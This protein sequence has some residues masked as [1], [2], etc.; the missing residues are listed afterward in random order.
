MSDPPANWLLV[1]RSLLCSTSAQHHIRKHANKWICTMDQPCICFLCAPPRIPS[2][3]YLVYVFFFTFHELL[4]FIG[5]DTNG[6]QYG[7]ANLALWNWW[8]QT[9]SIW[10]ERFFLLLLLLLLLPSPVNFYWWPPFVVPFHFCRL[11]L[12]QTLSI[13]PHWVDLMFLCS[14]SVVGHVG[15][16]ER[17]TTRKTTVV[18]H[19]YPCRT[20]PLF[21]TAAA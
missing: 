8:L 1:I 16:L 6:V 20:F 15:L 7:K 18:E 11:M 19:Y 10:L 12:L 4:E 3:V 14:G 5:S 13:P 9:I 2:R 21:C 17:S